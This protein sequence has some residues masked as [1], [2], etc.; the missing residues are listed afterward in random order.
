M[1]SAASS[2]C[3]QS[4]NVPTIRNVKGGKELISLTGAVFIYVDLDWETKQ[5][6][7]NQ[8]TAERT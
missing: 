1:G 5:L 6:K 2:G 7:L 8:K 4:I 3:F